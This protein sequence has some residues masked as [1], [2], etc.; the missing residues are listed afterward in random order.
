MNILKFR[1][2]IDLIKKCLINFL[3]VYPTDLLKWNASKDPLGGIFLYDLEKDPSESNN[4]ATMYPELVIKLMKEA[5]NEI[6]NAPPQEF[7]FVSHIS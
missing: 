6:K 4:L 1:E 7:G 5:E 3:D 2:D